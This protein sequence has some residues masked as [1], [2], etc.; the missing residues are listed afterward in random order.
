[1]CFPRPLA[2]TYLCQCFQVAVVLPFICRPL[3]DAR[4]IT[5]EQDAAEVAHEALIREWPTL[6]GWLEEDRQGLWLHRQLTEAAQAWVKL[7]REAGALYRGARLAQALEWAGDAGHAAE[8]NALEREFLA[9]SNE[10]AEREALERETARQRELDTARQLAVTET[11]RAEAAQKLGETEKQRAEDQTRTSVQLRRRALYLLGAFV[12]AVALAGAALYFGDRARQI[13]TTAQAASRLAT[14]RELAAD[15]VNNLDIDQERSVLLALQAM[16]FG[17]APETEGALHQAV[18]NDRVQLTLAG[19]QAEVW[20]VAY[21]HDGSRVATASQDKTARIWEAATGKLLLTLSGH[22]ESVN[23]IAFSPDGTRIATTSDDHTAK[24]WDA[25]TGRELFTVR[26][27][28]L[29]LRLAFS[30]DGTRPGNRQR[31]RDGQNLGRGDWPGAAD[32]LWR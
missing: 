25:A 13:A 21:S 28:D 22:T 23:G 18:M 24:V 29:V 17:D 26:H 14:A 8:L 9:A 10:T 1:M 5:T 19:H 7:E 30:P 12:L 16:S 11:A 20:T 3:A 15:A 32:P 31:G 4:L 27:G 2:S 6:R